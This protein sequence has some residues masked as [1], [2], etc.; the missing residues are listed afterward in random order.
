MNCRLSMYKIIREFLV[1]GGENHFLEMRVFS[2]FMMGMKKLM[3]LL[4]WK[5]KVFLFFL[6]DVQVIQFHRYR[7]AYPVGLYVLL[8]LNRLC[9][10][11][12][13]WL[14]IHYYLNWIVRIQ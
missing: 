14:E 13:V 11:K 6:P 7:P 8:V 10:P 9:R 12:S 4:M 5:N 3:I 1:L 2:T